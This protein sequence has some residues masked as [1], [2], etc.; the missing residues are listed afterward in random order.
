MIVQIPVALMA[1]AHQ[2]CASARVLLAT[3]D[4]DCAANRAYETRQVADYNGASVQLSDVIEMVE[5][6]EIFVQ[7]IQS[8]FSEQGNTP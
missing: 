7:Q 3:G 5:Q 8:K 6:T 4:V 1:K 2:A